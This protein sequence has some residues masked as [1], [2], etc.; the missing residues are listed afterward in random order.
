MYDRP[1]LAFKPI[2]LS[3][4]HSL[5]IRLSKTYEEFRNGEE[6]SSVLTECLANGEIQLRK[7]RPALIVSSTSW[8]EDEDFSVLFTALKGISIL[9]KYNLRKISF[10]HIFLL[11]FIIRV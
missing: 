2:D 4:K 10:F 3:E 6:G 9:L 7:Q 5:L 1:P 8:T 11:T